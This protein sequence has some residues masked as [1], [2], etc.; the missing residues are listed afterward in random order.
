MARLIPTSQDC[1]LQG[2]EVNEIMNHLLERELNKEIAKKEFKTFYSETQAPI[3]Y[4]KE[5]Y[6]KEIN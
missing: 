4:C 5:C 1:P 2:C 3:I 6:Q